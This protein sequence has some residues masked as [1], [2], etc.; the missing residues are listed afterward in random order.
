MLKVAGHIPPYQLE[1]PRLEP[2]LA[3]SREFFLVVNHM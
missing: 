3:F 2:Y 1:A